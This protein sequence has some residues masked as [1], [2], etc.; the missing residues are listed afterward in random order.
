[1]KLKIAIS[2]ALAIGLVLG[3]SQAQARRIAPAEPIPRAFQGLWVAADNEAAQ[4]QACT[5]LSQAPLAASA[6]SFSYIKVN[7]YSLFVHTP[8]NQ[9]TYDGAGRNNPWLKQT[10]THLKGTVY[11]SN[12]Y[13]GRGE[14]NSNTTPLK[15][16]WRINTRSYLV[17]K[18]FKPRKYYRCYKRTPNGAMYNPYA[19]NTNQ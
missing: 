8:S 12:R 6:A 9:T 5:V 18:G 11:P 4:K 15:L 1:M 7:E 3:M 13:L 2:S 17:A 19:P 14:F 10:A 16:D